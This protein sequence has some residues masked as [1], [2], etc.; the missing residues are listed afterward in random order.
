MDDDSL[1]SKT[2]KGRLYERLAAERVSKTIKGVSV[3][4]RNLTRSVHD[5]RGRVK[6]LVNHVSCDFEAG[7][8]TAIIGPSG[9]GKSTL[10]K[11]LCG[12]ERAN[13]GCVYIGGYPYYEDMA[14]FTSIFSYLP[15]F[16]DLFGGLT[17]YDELDVTGY[18]R[19]SG[20]VGGAVRESRIVHF[21]REFNLIDKM[22]SR[23]S[24]LSGGEKKRVAII[25]ALLSSPKVLFLDEPTAPLDPG[26]SDD[27]VQS[28]K[29]I[30]ESGNTTI[31]FV[32]HDPD[33]L[34]SVDRVVVMRKEESGGKIAF[35]GDKDVFFECLGKR[36]GRGKTPSELVKA[37]FKGF[38]E[39]ESLPAF[40]EVGLKR[41]TETPSSYMSDLEVGQRWFVGQFFR[42]AVRE[43]KKFFG[44]GAS[45]ALL[46]AL[47]VI[48][49]F[50]LGAVVN[51]DQLYHVYS[52]TKSM[53]FAVSAG[54]FFTGVFT[55]ISALGCTDR[56]RNEQMH[57]MNSGALAMAS[58]VVL[59]VICAAQS[60][61]LFVTFLAVAGK[62]PDF[63]LYSAQYD[64]FTTILFCSIS[65]MSL[66]LFCGAVAKQP[67]YIAPVLVLLQLVFSGI[68]FDL[69]DGNVANVIS[70]VI[71]CKWAM[72]AFGAI[73]NL[74][75][76][77]NTI[78][79]NAGEQHI[80]PPYQEQFEFSTYT[81]FE[82]WFV[83]LILTGVF[84]LLT[85][86]VLWA[87]KMRI[88][89]PNFM[90]AR[91]FEA[92]SAF[93]K[94]CLTTFS[95]HPLLW[96][97]FALFTVVAT[98]FVYPGLLPEVNVD[99][100]GDLVAYTEDLLVSLPDHLNTFVEKLT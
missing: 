81:L 82:S 36:Y 7:K 95:E 42:L 96:L 91:S 57:G 63:T 50:I 23:I 64:I 6:V 68:I 56:I 75:S 11:A 47:P 66:G 26:T 18:L 72:N 100:F 46:L 85:L 52:Y 21:L 27:F 71:S 59:A 37:L 60:L 33:A 29:R 45:S 62:T 38:A 76:L 55:G 99:F 34:L 15:Q 53:M 35:C 84:F 90:F 40:P 4:C 73:C 13:E 51:K 93:I 14:A 88:Y 43:A 48:I 1:Y 87:G 22:D 83:L 2:F 65:A 49:G 94:G 89:H 70:M 77:P 25:S 67:A 5:K 12:I 10:L 74:N 69:G 80:I 86:I 98:A 17:V 9:C 92:V 19:T 3:S 32:T 79:T 44:G 20:D 31:V 58:F 78:P 54:A 28:L 30:S 41:S 39:R 16:D 97:A 8:L 24:S 61:L